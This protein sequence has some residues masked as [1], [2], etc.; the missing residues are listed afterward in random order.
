MSQTDN[1]VF[2]AMSSST[3]MA[4]LEHLAVKQMHIS[5]LAKALN[6]SV[7]VVAKH[8]K[9]LEE[10]ELV[11]RQEFGKTHILNIKTPNISSILDQFAGEHEIEMPKGATLLDALRSVSAIDIKKVGNSEFVVSADGE[12]G[13]FLY[14]VNGKPLDKTVDKCILNEDVTIEWKRL[15]PVTQKKLSIKIKD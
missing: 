5:G 10:A 12:E 8:I 4:I 9:I 13:L 3:R 14:E 15:I 11:E 1:K 7:P 6:I 2:K